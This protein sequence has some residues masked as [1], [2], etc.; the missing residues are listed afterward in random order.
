MTTV[1][2][3]IDTLASE[4]GPVTLA[5]GTNVNIERIRTRQLMRLLKIL[6]RGAGGALSGLSFSADTSADEFTTQLIGAVIFSIPEAE[7]ETIGFI[8]SMVSPADLIQG[9]RLSKAEMELNEAHYDNLNALLVNPDLDD[10]V[11]IIERIVVVE[12]PHVLALGKRL[13]V[14]FTAQKTNE[15]AK[16]SASSKKSTR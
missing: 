8:Q 12:G 2:T 14:L 13:A 7:E 5:D 16:R 15:T 3:D 4:P 10:L 1:N 11:T 6:T 9:N